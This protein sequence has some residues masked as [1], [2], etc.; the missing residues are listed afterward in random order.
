[1]KQHIFVKF[2]I[3]LFHF[4]YL[5]ETK[6]VAWRD[7]LMQD[8]SSTHCQ[9]TQ[10]LQNPQTSQNLKAPRILPHT[11]GIK[12]DSTHRYLALLSHRNGA[13]DGWVYGRF[14]PRFVFMMAKQLHKFWWLRAIFPG[15]AITRQKDD[16]LHYKKA[17]LNALKTCVQVLQNR[18][19][20]C[21]FPEGTSSLGHKHLPFE[22]GAA[23]L[24]IMSQKTRLEISQSPYTPLYILPMSVFYDEPTLLGGKAFV[25]YD[26]PFICPQ[27]MDLPSLHSLFSQKLEQIL[28]EYDSQESQEIAHF[29]ASFLSSNTHFTDYYANLIWFK[30]LQN[31]AQDSQIFAT[32]LHLTQNYLKSP[33]PR[34]YKN[35]PIYPQN[36]LLSLWTFGICLP[37]VAFSFLCNLLPLLCGNFAAKLFAKEKHTISL[38]K[39]IVGYGVG[40]VWWG[41]VFVVSGICGA[42]GVYDKLLASLHRDSAFLDLIL[43]CGVGILLA[44]IACGLGIWG[45]KLYGAFKKHSIALYNALF[46]RTRFKIFKHFKNQLLEILD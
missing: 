19:I 24:A 44:L 39:A 28:L 9:A 20:L 21:V 16:P 22:Q 38:W 34:L 1:M 26:E 27:D 33:L 7:V 37:V 46:H 2:F 15:I 32:I 5:R 13:L 29:L 43:G 40:F 23:R 41:G 36:T 6:L 14:I 10:N 45:L 42:F 4:T 31:T 8:S 11:K 17:N 12:L 3:W 25:V 30:S 18:Q 35:A